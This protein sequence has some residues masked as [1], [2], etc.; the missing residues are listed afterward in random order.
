MI[1]HSIGIILTVMIIMITTRIEN[2]K[3]KRTS[4]C[5]RIKLNFIEIS[6]V[7]YLLFE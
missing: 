4:S 6:S 2:I 5:I 3:G 1:V 7:S